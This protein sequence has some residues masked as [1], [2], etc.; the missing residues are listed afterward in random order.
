MHTSTAA[1]LVLPKAEEVDVVL[2][3]KDL[4]IGVA[5]SQGKGKF[6]RAVDVHQSSLELR[7]LDLLLCSELPRGGAKEKLGDGRHA[8][9]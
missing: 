6:Q 9:Q 2:D 3:P 8:G 4:R 5:R 1:V 7:A